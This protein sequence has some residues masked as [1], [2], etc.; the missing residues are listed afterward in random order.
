[1]IKVLEKTVSDKIAAG[2]VIERPISVVKELVEN[3]IDAGASRVTLEIRGGGKTFIRVTDNGCGI[4]RTEAETAFLRHATSK[5]QSLSDLASVHSLG[6]RGEALASIAAVTRVSLITRPAGEKAGTRV[7]IH[8]GEVIENSAVGCPEGTTIIVSDLFYNT[9]ARREFLKSDGAES[10][11]IIEFFSE[12]SIAFPDIRF[13]MINNGRILFTSPGSGDILKTVMSVYQRKEYGD[14]I[15]LDY[16]EGAYQVTGCISRPSLSRT[17]RREQV[18]FVN[19]RVVK[20]RVMEKGVTEGYRERLFSGRFPVIFLLLQVSP[21]DVDVNI[22]PNKRE[23]RFHDERKISSLISAAVRQALAADDAIV[24]AGDYFVRGENRKSSRDDHRDIRENG[25][26]YAAS[27]LNEHNGYCKPSEGRDLE[28]SKIAKYIEIKRTDQ[29]VLYAGEEYADEQIDIKNILSLK[30][31]QSRKAENGREQPEKT[32][33]IREYGAED[34]DLEPEGTMPFDFSKLRITGSVFDTY[35]TAVDSDHFYMIDQHA[36]QE[37]IFY[38]KLV[39][40][41][42]S[43]NKPGQLIMTPFTFDV[44]PAM[45]EEEDLWLPD[46]LDMG[47]GI[48]EFGPVEYIVKEIPYFMEISESESFLK[49]YVGQMGSMGKRRNQAV[50]DKLITRS[51]KAAI[52]AHDR[53][54]PEEMSALLSDLRQCANPFSCPHGRPTVI[55]FSHYDIEKMFKRA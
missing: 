19:G 20:S 33:N 11:L 49:D 47:Y 25:N 32:G 18:Y 46:L 29:S 8:G 6:F 37:R 53:L 28:K 42:L 39:G 44:S 38:E 35:I 50:I 16:T 45:K 40:E 9:P 26:K 4:P 52:K 43:D 51:C 15:P 27:K 23:V 14:L 1:M 41:Y 2:E 22:H 31:E 55:R 54:S 36:A 21:E 12:I 13:Q 10:G 48:E 34:F 24:E 30:R 17:T 7:T 3:S 5:I